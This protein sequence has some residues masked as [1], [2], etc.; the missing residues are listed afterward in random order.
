MAPALL[1][2][3]EDSLTFRPGHK[4]LLHQPS[5]LHPGFPGPRFRRTETE[6]LP[7]SSAGADLLLKGQSFPR[8]TSPPI[9]TH[10]KDTTPDAVGPGRCWRAVQGHSPGSARPMFSRAQGS[11]HS[12]RVQRQQLVASTPRPLNSRTSGTLKFPS[13]PAPA[14]L[15][16]FCLY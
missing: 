9:H 14:R 11:A 12:L 13:E 2:S 1:R 3:L 6:H 4:L 10:L 8:C 15:R 7:F 16:D 5:G